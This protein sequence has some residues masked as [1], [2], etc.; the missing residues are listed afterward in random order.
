MRLILALCLLSCF[1]GKLPRASGLRCYTCLDYPGSTQPCSNPSIQQCDSWKDSC[2]SIVVTAEIYGMVYTRTMKNCSHSFFQCNSGTL[3][4]YANQS[5]ISNDN[6][7][8]LACSVNCC[9]GDLCNGQVSTPD[10]PTPTL[11]S[12]GGSSIV[13][14][15]MPSWTNSPT[16]PPVPT[17]PQLSVSTTY[18]PTPTTQSPT[19]CRR[20]INNTLESPG[21]PNN[22]PSYTSCAATYY[23]P[24]GAAVNITFEHFDLASRSNDYLRIWNNNYG[25]YRTYRGYGTGQSVIVTGRY[26][27]LSFQSYCC[28]QGRGFRL[29]F[30][31]VYGVSTT[32]RPTPTTQSPTACRRI[33]NN[34][35]ESPGYPINYPSNTFCV[36]TYYIPFG[37]AVNITFEHFDLSTRSIAFLRIWNNNDG[38]Y[39]TYSGYRTGQS[40]IVTG[41]Y[42]TLVFQSY[43]CFQGRGFRLLFIP[44]YGVSTTNRPTPTTQSPT[45]CRKVVNNT[46][47]SPGYPN[48][49]PRNTNC[50][51]N[52]S[53]PFGA[54]L[55]I[56]F[57]H[58]DLENCYGCGCDYLSIRTDNGGFNRTYCG[59]RT[60]QSVIVTGRYAKLTFHSDSSVQKTGF[61][62]LA[63]PVYGVSSTYRPTPTTQSPTACRRIINNTLESP[64]YPNNYPSYT[65]CAATYY[66]PF[67]AA[68]NITFEHF[69]LASRS[70]D[71]LRIW[72]N[73]YGFYRTYRGY[74]TGQSVIVTGR[75]VTLSFQSYCCFQGRGFRLLFIPVYGVL[76]TN[77]PT[78]TT[79][80]LTACRKVVN[81]TLE[82][83][84][85]PN[86]YPRNTNCVANVSIPLGAALNITFE[87]FDLENCYGC[88]CDYLWIRNDNGGFNRKYCGIRTGQS[89]IVTGRYVKLTFRSDSSVQR[90]GFRL[91]AFPVYGVSTTYR[92]TPTT[93]SPSACRRIINNT[94][95]SPGYPNNYPSYKSCVA[96]YYI[97]YGA[98]VNI[99]FEYFYLEQYRYSCSNDYLR[100]SNNNGG[101]YGTY[102]GYRT[103]QSV[104]VTGRYVTLIFRSNCCVQRRGFRLLFIPVYG[105]WTTQRP[106]PTTQSPSACRQVVNDV[107]ESP[108]YPNN[109]PRSKSCVAY[110]YTRF[111]AALNIT[112]EHFDLEYSSTC[113]YD[114]LWITN[115]NYGFNRKYCGNR[116]G[117]S[118]IV[119]GRY[120]RLTFR[121][122]S[123]VQKTGFRLLIF[124]FYRVSTTYRPTPTTQSPTA[125]RRIINNTLESPGYPN[126]YPSYK[127]CVA[128]YYIPY[129]AAVNIT[130]EYFDL[131]YRYSCSYDYLRIRN[132]NYGFYRTY[133][134][135]R[136]GQS[137]IVTGRYVTLTFGSNCCVQRRGFR[138]LFVPVYGYGVSTTY[139]PTPTTQSPTA[140]RRIIN[141]VLESPGYPNNYPSY[142]YCVATY[143]IPY[144]AAV[145]ITFEYFYL[146][147]YGYSCSYDYL[148]IRNNNGG[149]SGT[150]CGYR[151]GQSVI[152]T[153]RYVTLIFR[154]NCCV[155]RR[156]F[157]LLFIPVYSVSTTYRPTPTTQ[158]PT[159]CRRIINN[160][161][162]SPGYPNNYPSY[163]YCV[164]TYYIPF[165]AAVNIKFQY[166]YLESYCSNDYLR[167]RNN[168]GGFYRTYCGYRTGQSVIVTGRYVTLTF[169]SNCCVQRR[170]FRLLFVP[171]YGVSTT[172]RPTPTT[173]SPTA[174]RRII[175]NTLESPGYPNNYP[176]YKYCVATYYIPFGAAVNITFEHFD[177]ANRSY[178]YLRI[179]NNN[180]GFYRTYR[181]Y[182]TGQSVIVTGRYV[183]LSF[184]SYCCFQGRGFRLLFIPVYGVSTTNRPTPTTQSPTACRRIIN[185]TLESPGYPNNY[186]SYKYCVATYYIPFGAAVNITFEHF[187]LANRSYD[188]LRI[189]NNNYGF[190]RIYRG[191][192]TGQSV[193]VTGR[194]VT[195]SFQSYCCFQGRGFR[196]LFIPV[197]GVSTTNRPTP[198]TQSPTACRRIINNTLESPGYPNNYPSYKY[199]VATYYIPFGAAVNITFEHFDLA[200]RSYDYLRIWNNNYGFYRIYRGYRTGQSVIVTGR[201]VTLSF[202]SYCCFQGRGFRLLFIPVYG[203]STT[204]RPTPTTQ[205]PTACR[206]IINNT[207]ESPGYPNNYPLYKSCVA[208]Y[209]IPFGAAVNITFEHFDLANRSNDYLRIW[210]N[211]YGFYRTYRGYRTGQSVIV[212]GRYVT[213]YF[214]SYC[215]FQGR[216]FRL[217]FI[218]VYGVSTT[219]RPT[220]TTQSPSACRR[221]INNTLE[222][223]GYPNN[224]PRYKYCV[225]TY[226][227]PYGAAV[228]ITFVHF[229]LEN[230]Y[231]CSNDY[232]RIWNNNYGFYGTYCGYRTGQSVIVTGRYVTLTF[233]SNCCVERTGFRLLFIP[234]YGVSTTYRPTPTTPTACRRVINN[235]LESP[236][237][238]N[239][240]PRYKYCVANV[241]IPFGGAL[242]ITFEHFDLQYHYSCSYD[243]LRI[244]NDNGGFY[245]RYCGSRSGQS[246]IVTGRYLTLTFRSNCCVERTGFR[247]LFIPVY[248]VWTTHRP[249]PTT[250]SPSACR[251]VVNDVL[252]SPGY[253]NNYPRSK[254][255][256]AFVY[257]GFGAALN[258]TFEHFDLEYSSTC[259]Y[260]YLLITNDNGGFNRKYCGNRTGQ[261][262]IVTGRYARLTFRSD[263]SVQKTGFRLLIFRFYRVSTT[264]RPTPTTQSPTACR[265]V[266]NDVLESPGYPNNYPRSK[267]CVAFVYTGFGAALNITFEHFDLEYSSTCRYDYLLITNDNGGFNR[268]YCGNRTGQSVIVTG[269]Y[270]RLT[271][272][273]D[274]SVQ[275]T[276]FRLLIFRFYRVST[277]Y[278][279]TPT[280]QSPTACRQVVND[281]LESPGY[282]N[283]YPRS[284]SCVAFVYTGF[285]AAL[286]ITFE[287]FD[288]EY[289]STC[290]YDYLLITN[291]NGGFNR[292]YCGNRTGQ[293]VIVTGRYARLTF[294]SD[295]SV[296]KTGF[297]LLIFRFYRVSTTYRPTPTTQ[298]PTAC[299][300]VVNDVLE[301]PGYPNNYPRSKYCVAFVYTGFGAALNITFEHFDLE[302]SSTCRYDYLLITNDNGGFNRKYCGNRTGQS[303]IV[304]GRYARLTFR[305]DSSVQKT[306]FRL[307]IF[308]FYRVSTTYRP[309]PT[310][311]SPTACRQVVNDVLESPGYP[312][313][314]PRSKY[315]VAFVYT[316]FGAALNIT[317]EHFDLEYSSTCRYDYLLITNDNGGFNRKYCGNRTG[318]SVIVTGRYARLTFRS[319]SSVQKT[320]FRLLIF[321]FYR[322]STTHRP[323]P[324][325]QTPSVSTTHRPTPTTQTP[326]GQSD[327][328]ETLVKLGE[329]KHDLDGHMLIQKTVETMTKNLFNVKKKK[330]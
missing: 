184:Q 43:C 91:L 28:F 263:S 45:A 66:I 320:G 162:E 111:G 289:S 138:L 192:R 300:Q 270:A 125:C 203:V 273:S 101:F 233:W 181:G 24:F 36:A 13:N 308:R 55:N 134:G 317:F 65:S 137:V 122:D 157:R 71:Y 136:T 124:R 251:Q 232:L 248:G 131:E 78:P 307:L 212:T 323:T 200:N 215:C 292:K 182:R 20:I 186:P 18:R 229:D 228:N 255:C 175:N 102:C 110:V 83:P 118:V 153:G 9:Y 141:N 62:L 303:V 148:W 178:D 172:Y 51:A 177:L 294:R 237:Y 142:K 275:K 52:V 57:E 156:G 115:D 149:F 268:K 48:M 26:V 176:S 217:L 219:N 174:C 257:T 260:D 104:I 211:N 208:T 259:R 95:E 147:Q 245:R 201:Y 225:A 75:Y 235:T 145:N 89:I 195:L 321:R 21:Y 35:L 252:E 73:N 82:S 214:R 34:T 236:G 305:S 316:G 226:Y 29:L 47:E 76:T 330:A 11:Q 106:T 242:N 140:C 113:R 17:T 302:Y 223:P 88:G 53:I 326:S 267:S 6:G 4:N 165:G 85:Y 185:N 306:G 206:R 87:H 109:Y 293:S 15:S 193:I 79:Q 54:A 224:Y 265:Q 205:S 31:P 2:R 158:S 304:T 155:Q 42:I 129:G 282:P 154:S 290:R 67:G 207:L 295:S 23:I 112:F 328:K 204:N 72:N 277:T 169:G 1:G 58:F 97:P 187:D 291:D 209:Y 210:N 27:T 116:T 170:G 135:Y 286:N 128:T 247:L 261:S 199:C 227:I 314:Y 327:E 310:T 171:V 197:Y 239:N 163:K 301:S 190:Y 279:P 152:V 280:T 105:V 80:S 311:Q 63:F 220:P 202:Q 319:D 234:V 92:P 90:T 69:D 189:W 32:Y 139:R 98:A 262:V 272:R 159:A 243:Y 16:Y 86:M 81:N 7:T 266:V 244:R 10:R 322:V 218:P 121:S 269:R 318:Q 114:Y 130:F 312:N 96:T 180:Y 250:Q 151:T 39:R 168:N 183:T 119:T 59:I 103:G 132:N 56:T 254:S 271:F 258:I 38:F 49:Y 179:W 70:N 285:G 117:Q 299:R 143:S 188:Y 278:R 37:A 313:N 107:L 146:A 40:V 64:G 133:C 281:V 84:G 240:Y 33:I 77:R 3:C 222:S 315:C 108:G 12:L 274:S 25:F 41:R 253:P 238:P 264:Y 22:Y 287:H 144:G 123:S 173:Q 164:A 297:R 161:L 231:Y 8:L 221:I 309:T 127:Y 284:K 241:S 99:T 93:Q 191:Y 5:I 61:R 249:T 44:V 68:V 167:I 19:A 50:V 329:K 194:Y 14:Y 298:S 94:L 325:T 100:I 160:V 213:L 230:R 283:N 276:G 120:A 126:N 216:G 296:Q 74:R 46:L 60:G 150:Y 324:T 166:F 198:T 30:I 256:V 246:V 288:L 196:L